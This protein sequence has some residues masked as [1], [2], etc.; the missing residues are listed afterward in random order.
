MA[1]QILKDTSSQILKKLEEWQKKEAI[2]SSFLEFYKGLLGI[3]A[4]AEERIK[5]PEPSLS[6]KA[7]SH[8]ITN[9]LPLM[10]LDE[11]D[12]DWSLLDEVFRKVAT[13]FADF[14]EL[15][16]DVPESLLDSHS[17]LSK[18]VVKAWFNGTDLP[19]RIAV[20]NINEHVLGAIVNAAMKPFLVAY[21]KALIDMV[22][23]NRW[24]KGYCPI[25][26]GSP[27][28]AFLEKEV[29]GRWLMC[30]RCDAQWRLQRLA[31][32]SCGNQDSK[33]L[34][35]FSD[36]TGVYRLY[37]CDK[38]HTYLKAIDLRNTKEDISLSLERLMTLDMDVQGQKKGY[39]PGYSQMGGVSPQ[40]S[41]KDFLTCP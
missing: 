6:K 32:P 40:L 7:A 16:G 21:S 1:N 37:V 31:C 18:K 33:L 13:I 23:Q 19:T 26:G 38:C 22:E 17:R 25:C 20:D 3:Q 41:L 9:G 34:S 30:S 39:Q 5:L 28:I 2:S 14:P 4:W 27:D 29:G 36:D 11:L 35:C 24:G 10:R 12:L 8:R 15:L